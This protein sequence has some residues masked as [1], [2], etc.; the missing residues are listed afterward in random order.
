MSIDSTDKHNLRK[1][2]QLA[3]ATK[4][5]SQSLQATVAEI[6]FMQPVCGVKNDK[7]HTPWDVAVF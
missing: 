3:E 5:P 1:C 2:C 4:S 7:I 6:I